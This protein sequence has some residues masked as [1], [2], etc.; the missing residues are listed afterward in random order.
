MI[1]A[2]LRKIAKFWARFLMRIHT[3][4][5]FA[6]SL[7]RTNSSRF[8]RRTQRMFAA[9]WV[10]C[11]SEFL[12]S[13][14]FARRFSY[15]ANN[16]H[17][18]AN[19]VGSSFSHSQPEVCGKI[20]FP[21]MFASVYAALHAQIYTNFYIIFNVSQVQTLSYRAVLWRRETKMSKKMRRLQRQKIR[22]G[23]TEFIQGKAFV[24]QFRGCV[25]R[26]TSER[27]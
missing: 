4:E 16:F 7:L 27:F 24:L 13:S 18:T 12:I 9:L 25:A 10:P 6:N 15:L 21:N 5:M 22:R 1:R 17:V 2:S 26:R 19:A 11:L 20:I 23:A 14:M 3:C 8:F